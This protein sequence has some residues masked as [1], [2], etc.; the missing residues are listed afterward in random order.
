MIFTNYLL[1][2]TDNIFSTDRLETEHT[3]KKHD[4]FLH[5]YQII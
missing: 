5:E 1:T 4:Y 3:F 2:F